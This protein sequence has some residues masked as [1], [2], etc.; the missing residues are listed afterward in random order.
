MIILF[1]PFILFARFLPL[2]VI[3]VPLVFLCALVKVY[4]QVWAEKRQ[5]RRWPLFTVDREYWASPYPAQLRDGAIKLDLTRRWVAFHL[6]PWQTP[7]CFTA[8]SIKSCRLIGEDCVE[9]M[10]RGEASPFT[11]YPEAKD[12]K[13]IV[14]AIEMLRRSPTKV[15]AP[16]MSEV[17]SPR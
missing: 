7:R 5:K 1:V 14:E 17:S 2:L 13:R 16:K 4:L 11:A 6:H 12:A 9:M 15:A 8:T 10:V 3:L